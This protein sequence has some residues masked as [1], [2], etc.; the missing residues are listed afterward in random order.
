MPRSRATDLPQRPSPRVGPPSLRTSSSDSDSLNHHSRPRTDK[1]PKL[2]NPVNQKKLGSRIAELESQLGQAQDQLKCL[3]NQLAKKQPRKSPEPIEI[4]EPIDECTDTSS[5]VE[6]KTDQE[7]ELTMLKAKLD[8]RDKELET[9][10][11]ENKNA[12]KQVDEKLVKISLTESEIEELS[13]KVKKIEQEL[14]KSKIGA[15]HIAEKLEAA[16][17]GKE[18]LKDE[19]KR[20]RVQTEQWRKAADAAANILAGE[21][22]EME[23]RMDKKNYGIMFERANN[24]GVGRYG[25]FVGS[26]G[27]CDDSDDG[28]GGGKR[29]G[30]SGIR[31]FVGDFWKKKGH[32]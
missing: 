12:K 11:Q 25:G 32:R 10:R 8:E 18:E 27:V 30:S 6:P 20:L 26:P 16:E 22:F 2:S 15:A 7:N 23:G 21:S 4:Q 9:L 14:E 29:K 19:M 28:F 13:M 17:K 1:S 3:K 31:M 5:S 24:G